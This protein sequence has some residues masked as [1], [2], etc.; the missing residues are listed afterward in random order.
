[1]LYCYSRSDVKFQYHT[2]KKSSILTQIGRFRTVI[3]IWIHQWL[4]N[5]AQSFKQ[6]RRG[7][8]LF[9][10]V[11]CQISRTH[12]RMKS[13]ILTR[14]QR[15]RTVTPVWIHRWLWNDARSLKLYRG[16]AL[17]FFGVISQIAISHRT[18]HRRLWPD[19]HFR[20]A[21]QVWINPRLW[22]EAHSL[23]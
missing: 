17:S 6:T 15:F 4:R 22:T 11:I 19:Q 3:P 1:M 14:I 20:S 7:A 23:T 9:L 5:D 18:N 16:G 10:N 12:G 2:A 21:T 13:T 8:L